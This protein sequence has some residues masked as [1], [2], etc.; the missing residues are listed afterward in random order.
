MSDERRS[1]DWDRDRVVVVC[2]VEGEQGWES[3]FA[4]N[5]PKAHGGGPTTRAT[6]EE[7]CCIF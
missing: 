4:L 3:E 1:G 6:T 7:K 2:L 5:C